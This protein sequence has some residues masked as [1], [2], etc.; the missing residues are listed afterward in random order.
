MKITAYTARID[1]FS[2]TGQDADLL[3]IANRSTAA[4]YAAVITH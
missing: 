1:I 4:I 2:P 3:Y